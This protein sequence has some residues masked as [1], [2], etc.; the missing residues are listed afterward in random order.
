MDKEAGSSSGSR[1]GDKRKGGREH[2]PEEQ[3]GRRKLQETPSARPQLARAERAERGGGGATRREGSS[4]RFYRGSASSE[5]TARG[6]QDKDRGLS[7]GSRTTGSKE[8]PK[9]FKAG[10]SKRWQPRCEPRCEN[11][12]RCETRKALG[13]LSV[14]SGE[15]KNT[16]SESL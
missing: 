14:G 5:G 1:P 9:A 3:S 10:K 16:L 11:Q 7:A 4:F 6:T 12:P 8:S 15:C 2:D 13:C